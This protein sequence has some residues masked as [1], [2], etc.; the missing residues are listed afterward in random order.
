MANYEIDTEIV[1]KLTLLSL[2]DHLSYLKKELKEHKEKGAYMH[3]TDAYESEHELIPAFKR[4]I[5]YY[6]G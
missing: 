2:K 1:D 3:S 5:R 4:I 6:G